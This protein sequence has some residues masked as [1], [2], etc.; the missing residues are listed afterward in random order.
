[1]LP[2]Q[3]L[4]DE[5]AHLHTQWEDVHTRLRVQEQVL[6]E[7]IALYVKGKA[8]RPETMMQEVEQM[9]AECAQRFRALMDALR[10]QNAQ[11]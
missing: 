11:I 5:L 4:P 10:A 3:G 6:S 7:A 9:R 8:A 2:P 1:M